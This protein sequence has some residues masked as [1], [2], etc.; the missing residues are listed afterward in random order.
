MPPIGGA[1][2][3]RDVD[4]KPQPV[5]LQLAV[6]VVEHDAGFDDAGFVFD[7]ER[8]QLVQMLGEINDDAVIDGLATCEVPAS[9]RRG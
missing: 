2:G 5:L 7:V 4:R 8:D 1:R 3:G 9:T 6:E